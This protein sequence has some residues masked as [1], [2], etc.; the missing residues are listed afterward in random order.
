MRTRK[1]SEKVRFVIARSKKLKTALQVTSCVNHNTRVDEKAGNVDRSKSEQNVV[2][3]D[4]LDFAKRDERSGNDKLMAYYEGLGVKVKRDNVLAMEHIVS[5]SPEFFDDMS[6]QQVEEWASHQL[7]YYK[8]TFGENNVKF[9]VLHLDEKTPHLHI[10]TSTEQVKEVVSKNRYGEKR[11]M[12]TVLNAKRFNPAFFKKHQ[13][14][15]ARHNAKYGLSRG[16]KNSTAKHEPLRPFYADVAK[17]MNSDY[18]SAVEKRV[19]ERLN[20]KDSLMSKAKYTAEEVKNI[21]V[22]II[23]DYVKANKKLKTALNNKLERQ[24]YKDVQ[25]ARMDADSYKRKYQSKDVND[26]LRKEREEELKRR[27]EA[28]EKQNAEHRQ[29]NKQLIE[30]NNK[31]ASENAKM[32]QQNTKKNIYNNAFRR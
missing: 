18:T 30:A 6:K 12:K 10:I 21:V 1:M 17:A 22:D 8:R 29:Q 4:T 3:I 15:I 9:A 20:K 2:M 28:S 31:L 27:L 26:A 25:N 7:D 19:N 16:I 5:A 11:S 14:N 23:S 32:K 13:S 24:R